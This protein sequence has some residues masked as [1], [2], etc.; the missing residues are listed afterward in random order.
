[1]EYE[2]DYDHELALVLR[3]V[4]EECMEYGDNMARSEEDGWFYAD[5]DDE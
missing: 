4:M 3:D 2:S 1:M 5:V